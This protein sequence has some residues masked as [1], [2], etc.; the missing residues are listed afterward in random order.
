[1]NDAIFNRIRKPSRYLGDE[2]NSRPKD[3]GTVDLRVALAFPDVYEVGMSHIGF[4][5]LY[6]ILN[7]LD[8]LAAERAY[9]PWPDMEA[10]LR[11][12]GDP[13]R[14]LESQRP[15]A[16]FDIIGFTLQYELSYTNLLNMLDLAGI[17]RRREQR[18]E[19]H[20]LIVVG[21]PC[22]YNPEPLAD[23][24]DL[25]VIG[26]GEEAVVE[27]CALVR[28]GRKSGWDR[29]RLL[30]E[31]AAVEGVYVPSLYQV[32]YHPDGT[33]RA[34]R[35]LD[36]A[37]ERVRRRVLAD[38]DSAP[39]PLRPIVPFM[40]TVHDRVAV[41]VARGCTRGCRFC[42]AGYI[43]R[44][45]RER[46][47]KT[48]ASIVEQSLRHS[49]YDEVSLLSLS[50]GDY[51]QLE[52][53][54]KHLM[55]CHADEK[56]AISLPSLRVGSLSAELM[57]E[58]RKVRKTG[59]TL[60]PEAGTERLRDVINKGISEQDLLDGSRAAF[61]LGWR[62]IKLYFMIGLPTE[63]GDDRAAIV[64]LAAR[65]KQTGKGSAG[66]ADVNVSVS[67][68]VP[69]P[70]T[71]FQW[72]AQIGLE[73]TVRRQQELKEGL[74]K[75]KL[76]FKYHDPRMSLLEGI[77]A[78][79]DRR[80]GRLLEAAFE[81]GCR[82]DG[83]GE[84]F[85][86]DLWQQA[87][88]QTGTDPD[89]YL[90]SRDEQEI[91]PW[92]HIDCGLPKSFFLRERR[93]A[94][95]GAYTAD[96]RQ[97][98]CHGCGLCDFGQIR[99]R[100]S[101]SLPPTAGPVRTAATPAT[102]SRCKVRL[103]LRKEGRVRFVSHLEFMTAFHRAVRR[104]KLPIGYSGGFHPHPK[105]AFPDALPTGIAS[106]A[107]IIDLELAHPLPADEVRSRLNAE[108]P[109]GLA[110]LQAAEVAWQT[111]SPSASIVSASYRVELPAETPADLAER[112][113]AFLA[114]ERVDAERQTKNGR[115]TIDIRKDVLDLQ[116][117]A[118]QLR[119]TLAKGSPLP[120]LGHLLGIGPER[121]RDLSIR[122]TAVSMRNGLDCFGK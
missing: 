43:Y 72:E 14:S 108:L 34:V 76:R 66:G 3:T 6:R 107:E 53:L 10:E 7:D 59:F 40:N 51:S 57:D 78:R 28:Q 73:E 98:A 36:G 61:A 70:H 32:D 89:R 16:A 15:L 54:L 37:P 115:K 11:S 65:V 81:L 8:W 82:F 4:A 12:A 85:R 24:F 122:K 71:P 99:P 30:R 88:Q 110:I 112:C 9:A 20:P 87:M 46:S 60:A 92:D 80:L 63:T 52:P 114:A 42:Q 86:W 111:P 62:L 5:I 33:L 79:G 118:G 67:T 94:L 41:E 116:L 101:S 2:L 64:D 83:W 90:R 38:L 75:R 120:V 74:K 100:L 48:V 22:A 45:V 103:R 44:P 69:K 56:V 121:A 18:D 102:D 55:D 21:G 96:C 58:I 17:P 93:R 109:P 95:E 104:A 97:G 39:Y 29:Q 1:M 27:V 19:S 26:D 47:A 31:L 49:G 77:F 117:Q 119:L 35:P 25:A 113:A 84:H 105:I 13:L 91:L 50:T 23:F 68:F 106:D